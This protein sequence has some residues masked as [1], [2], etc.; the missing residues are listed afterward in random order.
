MQWWKLW[1]QTKIQQNIN[2]TS[3]QLTLKHK[4]YAGLVK[5]VYFFR[6]KCW[7]LFTKRQLTQWSYYL[8][9]VW[10]ISGAFFSVNKKCQRMCFEHFFTLGSP[11]GLTAYKLK[12]EYLWSDKI[13]LPPQINRI[14]F[15]KIL[16]IKTIYAYEF[17]VKM[18]EYACGRIIWQQN[19]F[20]QFE[21]FIAP[22]WLGQSKR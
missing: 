21:C 12:S 7:V 18:S 19:L 5:I 10:N 9:W 20:C 17:K 1:L 16:I 22:P 4:T 15:S 3:F 8:S 14:H 2:S 6:P 11:L 13:K